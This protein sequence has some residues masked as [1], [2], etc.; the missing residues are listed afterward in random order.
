MPQFLEKIQFSWNVSFA[1]IINVFLFL[2]AV[3]GIFLTW[4]QVR[5]TYKTQKA[6]FF[7]ELYSVMFS[8]PDLR[9]AYQQVEYDS[10]VY[11]S[12]FHGSKN[13]HLIDRLLSFA[14]LVCYLHENKMLTEQEMA[15]FRYE[16][17]RIYTNE[18]IQ[19]YLNFLK[20]FYH[21]N[22]TGTEPFPRYVSYCQSLL[23]TEEYRNLKRV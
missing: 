6:T 19:D 9:G 13:E 7:K 3:T 4:L 17:I 11:D 15:F 20:D 14:D 18:S 12:S 1:D 8:D 5:R 23:T 22:R 21:K 2:V 16:F 10:F